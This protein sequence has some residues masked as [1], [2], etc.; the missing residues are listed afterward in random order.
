MKHNCFMKIRLS[1]KNAIIEA[2]FQLFK[3]NPRASLA[4]IAGLAGVG[5]VT[6]HRYFSGR[7]ELVIELAKMAIKE[8]DQVAE[9]AASNAVTYTEALR[10]M[11]FALVPL[12]DRQWFLANQAV[13]GHTEIQDEYQ[14]QTQEMIEIIEL[15]KHEGALDPSLPS[16]WVSEAYDGLLFAAWEM[17]RKDELT[18]KQAADYA[19]KTFIGGVGVNH[20]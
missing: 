9:H 16:V 20:G 4:E 6:L 7:D 19:W 2:A 12:A 11:L 1:T 13:E 3:E 17:V 15:A 5:R 8:L 14:R 10:L 18:V